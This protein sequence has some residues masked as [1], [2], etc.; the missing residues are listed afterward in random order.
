MKNV[1]TSMDERPK[2]TFFQ[3]KPRKGFSFSLE[4]IFDDIRNR[5]KDRITYKIKIC[6]FYNDAYFT[7]IYNIIEAGFRQGSIV[8]HITGEVHF[9]NLL[10][11][12]KTVVLTIHDCGMVHRKNGLARLLIKKLYLHL[13]IKHAEYVT[14]VSEVTKREI[15]LYTKCNAEKIIVI[16]VA[17]DPIYKPSFKEFNSSNP[18]ILHIGLGSNKNIFRLIEALEGLTCNLTIIGKLEKDHLEAL[19][20]Y[21]INF[22]NYY[23][24]TQEEIFQK[25]KECDILAYI[26]TFEGFGMP[27]I[28]ANC[29]ERVVITSNISSMPEVAGDAA[30]LVDPFNIAEIRKNIMKLIEDK[31]YR[32]YLIR[33][34]RINKLRFDGDTIANMYYNLYS[35]ISSY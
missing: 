29:V 15:L 27:I 2:V 26:S 20:K 3:R 12:K 35:K 11:K 28:E 14:C 25:Y 8:N 30:C 32:E 18:N 24:L 31:I 17:V 10:M 7:K 21:K 33:E 16:P 19:Q 5:L 23:N 34:G 13:P 9:L 4:Y 1:S 22:S 6:K